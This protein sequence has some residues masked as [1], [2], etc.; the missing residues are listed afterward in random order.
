M[1][2]DVQKKNDN[3]L[4]SHNL[5]LA[6]VKRETPHAFLTSLFFCKGK[7]LKIRPDLVTFSTPALI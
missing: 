7:I 1:L 5:I 2:T 3:N 4:N 6:Q